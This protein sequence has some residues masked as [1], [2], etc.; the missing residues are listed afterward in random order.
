VLAHRAHLLREGSHHL[1]YGVLFEVA[2]DRMAVADSLD[3]V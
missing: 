3:V 1:E 2:Q